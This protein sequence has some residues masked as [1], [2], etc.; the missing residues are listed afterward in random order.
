M[1]QQLGAVG[2][3]QGRG[4]GGL[5]NRDHRRV[6]GGAQHRL[7]R[8]DGNSVAHHSLGEHRVRHLVQ[9][10]EPAG[11]RRDEDDVGHW[12]K[13]ST[14]STAHIGFTPVAV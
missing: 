1:D 6:G 3:P 8:V 7:D 12:V 2:E 9:R 13:S 11:E 4:M 10:S 5:G 14:P